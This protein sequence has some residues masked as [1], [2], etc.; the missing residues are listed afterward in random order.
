MAG[1]QAAI[2]AIPRLQAPGHAKVLGP[3]YNE[4]A[5]ALRTAGWMVAEVPTLAALAG[6]DLAVVVNPNNPDGRSHSRT[7][8][9]HVAG[10]VGRLVV[11]ESFADSRPDLSLAPVAGHPGILVLRS[12]GKFYG[13][14]GVRLGFVIGADADIAALAA[15][16]G[17]WNVSGMAI[18]L[19]QAALADTVW[20]DATTLRLKSETMR[21]DALAQSINWRLVGGTELFRLYWTA[22]AV[23]A[24]QRLAL[25]QIWSRTFPYSAHWLRL[26]MPGNANEWERLATAM[27]T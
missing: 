17:P 11:D 5:A 19:G 16:A 20:A 24:Q 8:L 7:D 25:H 26:G 27:R 3:T 18:A 21:L 2:Q 4:H 12:F 6:A 14:A 23:Q 10:K 13:L 1:A 15:M 9:L 22:D